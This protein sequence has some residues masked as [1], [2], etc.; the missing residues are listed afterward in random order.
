MVVAAHPNPDRSASAVKTLCYHG[1]WVFGVVFLLSFAVAGFGAGS[2]RQGPEAVWD[3]NKYIGLDQIKPGMKGYC[4]TEFGIA[5]IE[6]FALEVVDVVPDFDPGRDVILVKGLDERFAYAGAVAG[7]SGS[8]V[9]I[10]GRLAGALAYGW[11]YGKDALYGVTPI[12]DMLQIGQGT[13]KTTVGGYMVDFS[14]PIHFGTLESFSELFES[15]SQPGRLAPT[16][17][18]APLMTRGLSAAVCQRLQAAVE[19]YGYMVVPGGGSRRRGQSGEQAGQEKTEPKMQPG[20]CL[21]VPLVMGDITVGTF[22]TVT[23]VIG[24]KVYGFGH[25]FLGY[26][27]LNLPMATGRVHTVVASMVRSFKLC[28]VG[29]MVGALVTDEGAG[30]LGRLGAKAKMIPVRVEVERFNDVQK[31]R[32]DCQVVYNQLLTSQMV[33]L[34]ISGA[35]MYLGEL[36]PEHTVAYQVKIDV[37][38]VGPIVYKNVSTDVGLLQLLSEVVGPSGAVSMLLNNPYRPAEIAGIEISLKIQPRSTLGHIW[39][40]DISDTRVEPG[41]PVDIDVVVESV[42]QKKR[43]YQLR[44]DIPKDLAPG[45]YQLMLCGYRDYEQFLLKAVPHRF[46]ARSLEDL[47]RA[48][49]EALAVERDRLYCV[50]ILPP[51]GVTLEAAELPDLPATKVLVLQNAKRAMTSRPYQHWLQRSVKTGTVITGARTVRLTVER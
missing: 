26:G 21:T 14:K 3:P 1:L 44:V 35:A 34:V 36:P 32:Y 9:Y 37:A 47:V 13:T 11:L 51:A 22:G 45:Q 12:T 49:N 31:R 29:Q 42:R 24:D 8:P 40:V 28:S 7:C 39:S 25:P 41:E 20:A 50:L 5:G 38:G 6:K 17:L 30:I 19:P 18:R 15:W 43:R 4:L 33:S 2:D 46:V 10:Q 23:A 48:L 27:P 16:A